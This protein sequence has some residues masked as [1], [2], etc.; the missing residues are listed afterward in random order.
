[1]GLGIVRELS[2]D[3][4]VAALRC[5]SVDHSARPGTGIP[6]RVAAEFGTLNAPNVP[7]RDTA[8]VANVP[9]AVWGVA[10]MAAEFFY[11][12][13]KNSR[14]KALGDSPPLKVKN[15]AM[16]MMFLPVFPASRASNVPRS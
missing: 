6:P 15:A 12:G 1:M 16:M 10:S 14:L 8:T 5:R 4:Y 7:F 2:R 9:F 13:T 3:L 11:R